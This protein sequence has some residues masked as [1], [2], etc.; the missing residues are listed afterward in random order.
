M[1]S[2]ALLFQAAIAEAGLFLATWSVIL[3]HG[4]L[5]SVRRW[6]RRRIAHAHAALAAGLVHRHLPDP[7]LARIRRLRGAEPAELFAT[8][9]PHLRG[10]ERHWLGEVATRVGLVD[11][12]RRLCRSRLWWNRLHGARILTLV[13][14]DVPAVL[15][16]S[17]DPNPLVRSQVAECAGAYPGPESVDTL[18]DMLGDPSRAGRFSVQ[19]ALV[20]MGG[21]A[22]AP[23]SRRLAGSPDPIAALTGLRVARGLGDPRLLPPVLALSTHERPDVRVAAFEALG[24]MGG[25]A[26]AARLLEGLDDGHTPARTAA[27]TALGRMG[28]WQAAAALA[29]RLDDPAWDVRLA[30][31]RA[32]AALGPPGRLMLRKMLDA[33]NTFVAD[34]ARHVLDGAR[35]EGA[36]SAGP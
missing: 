23:L 36:R 35:I 21:L 9:A 32:L 31:G 28:Q 24:A 17:R 5:S 10:A 34:M 4:G 16:L 14:G 7:D 27:A 29:R 26:A 8:F 2:E 33:P 30:S 20:Q 12:A 1:I 19:D 22:V 25:D 3:A 11:R 18:V 6:R 15:A 13:G